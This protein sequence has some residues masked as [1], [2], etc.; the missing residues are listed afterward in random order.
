MAPSVWSY[1]GRRR[2]GGKGQ[3]GS[4]WVLPWTQKPLHQG[5]AVSS[6]VSGSDGPSVLP[7]LL[8]PLFILPP[9]LCFHW[10]GLHRPV[11]IFLRPAGRGLPWGSAPSLGT[12]PVLRHDPGLDSRGPEVLR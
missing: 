6:G 8:T 3:A 10:W 1:R 4:L 11:S 9:S 12:A 5:L 7:S 2:A